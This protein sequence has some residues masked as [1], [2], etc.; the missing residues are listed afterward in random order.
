V[1]EF[2]SGSF[3]RPD[4]VLEFPHVSQRL[5]ELGDLSVAHVVLE[6]GWR[7]STH[8]QPEVGGEWCQA[9]HVGVVLSGRIGILLED[10]STYEIGPDDVYEIPPGHDGW[11]IG[12]EAMVSIEWSGTRAFYAM[13]GRRNRTLAALLFTDVVDSTPT[14]KRLGDA[15]WREVLSSHFEATRRAIDRFHGREVKT[16]GD[17]F[18]AMFGGPAQAI[19]C[20]FRIRRAAASDDLRIRAGVHIGEVEI[21]PG[22]LRGIAV[23][24]AARIMSA[25]GDE[26]ILVSETV[27]ALAQSEGLRFEDRGAHELKGLPGEYHLFAVTEASTAG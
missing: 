23:H 15:R 19:E 7:W 6:P 9:R 8:I 21:V 24:E 26:E 20:G 4:E 1:G 2:R 11:V 18:L 5:V 14:A 27:R 3:S 16:T 10:G 17:G 22:D 25:A 13:P 12:D